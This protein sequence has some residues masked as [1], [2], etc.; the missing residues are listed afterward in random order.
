MARE[1]HMSMIGRKAVNHR[2]S[3]QGHKAYDPWQLQNRAGGGITS[4]EYLNGKVK[5][6]TDPGNTTRY[7]YDARTA[8]Q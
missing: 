6:V 3:R 2:C 7:E 8:C 4:Y 5:S 1:Q